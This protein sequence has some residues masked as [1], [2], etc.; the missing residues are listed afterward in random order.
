MT[1]NDLKVLLQEYYDDCSNI[2]VSVY[3]ILRNGDN[4][5]PV[6]I[7]IELDASNDLRDLFF[8]SLQE[9]VS[10][11]ED[12]SLINISSAD[13]RLDAVY[14]YDLEVPEELSS[15]E[16]ITKKDDIP[17]LNLNDENLSSIKA[18]L[19]EIGNNS[20]Q[21]SLY[22]KMAPVNIFGRTSLFL[23]KSST[24]LERLNEEFLRISSGFQLMRINN[25]L[26]VFNLETL[27]KSF[28]FHDVIKR[29]A[30]FGVNAIE[31]SSLVDNPAVLHDLIDDVKYARKLTRIAKSSPV[32]KAGIPGSAIVGF[33]KN[34]PKLSGKFRFNGNQDKVILDTKVSKDLLINLLMDNYLTSE[35]TNYYYTSVAKDSV[36]NEN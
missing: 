36:N 9:R 2:G 35:L 20:R 22:K 3:A 30:S 27:E 28:G 34:F 17:L 1:A 15:L 7:D 14:V 10:E 6:K 11:K 31:N 12:L 13:E 8:K 16:S 24:R 26:L 18:L 33:C 29:E 21:L 23:K 4:E 32:I 19:I 25:T 5:D